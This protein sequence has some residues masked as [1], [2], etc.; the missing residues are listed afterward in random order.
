MTL[1]SA[2]AAH[3]RLIVWCKA[4]QYQVEPDPAEMAKRYGPETPIPDWRKR[5]R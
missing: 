2:A 4:C 1:G 5:R 3:G